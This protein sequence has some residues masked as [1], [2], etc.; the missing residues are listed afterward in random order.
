ML[1][2]R[3]T[4]RPRTHAAINRRA[5]SR[6]A[7]TCGLPPA[8][9]EAKHPARSTARTVR[10]HGGFTDT[11]SWIIY[12]IEDGNVIVGDA[13]YLKMFRHMHEEANRG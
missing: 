12:W 4:C 8:G 9:R 11:I 7:P 1:G 13:H 5:P 6:R 10:L 3:P 2:L